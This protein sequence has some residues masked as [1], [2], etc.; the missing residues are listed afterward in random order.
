MPVFAA[1]VLCV[2]T[3]SWYAD[4][5]TAGDLLDTWPLQLTRV[6]SLPVGM[7]VSSVLVRFGQRR[8]S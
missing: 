1:V 8:F 3:V 7:V 2:L 6:L 5:E 4:P